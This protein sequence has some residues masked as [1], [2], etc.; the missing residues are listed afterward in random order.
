[1]NRIVKTK[2]MDPMSTVSSKEKPDGVVFEGFD[3]LSQ[4]G[5][6]PPASFL[7]QVEANAT[8]RSGVF[9]RESARTQRVDNGFRL[10]SGRFEKVSFSFIHV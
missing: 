7:R 3:A 1:M 4:T 5:R 8:S 9:G 6:P 10:R 2:S